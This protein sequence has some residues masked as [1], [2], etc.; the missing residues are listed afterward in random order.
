MLFIQFN[1]FQIFH[2]KYN[3]VLF[4]FDLCNV[5]SNVT[6]GVHFT[7]Y[8]AS[9]FNFYQIPENHGPKITNLNNNLNNFIYLTFLAAIPLYLALSAIG[10]NH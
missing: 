1:L 7:L 9:I 10:Q 6:L 2:F 4:L 3:V 8:N 5:I